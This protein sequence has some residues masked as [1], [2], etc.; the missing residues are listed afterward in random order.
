MPARVCDECR[1]R[2]AVQADACEVCGL[3]LRLSQTSRPDP[4]AY[5]F[6]R[7]IIEEQPCPEDAI[8]AYRFQRLV[9]TG[10][11]EESSHVLAVIRAT[12]GGGYQVDIAFFERL[13]A[14]GATLNQA[15]RIVR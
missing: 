9:A 12:E 11:D 5:D 14:E 8:E 7:A 13:L 4:A 6:V 3:V 15:V 1:L 10:L 2:Y